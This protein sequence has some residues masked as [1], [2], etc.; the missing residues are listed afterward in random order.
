VPKCKP[1]ID[2]RQVRSAMSYH[3]RVAPPEFFR[4][5]NPGNWATSNDYTNLDA[6]VTQLINSSKGCHIDGRAGTGK[7]WYLRSLMVELEKR[8]IKYQAMAPTNVAAQLIDGQTIAKFRYQYTSARKQLLNAM[9]DVKYVFIDEI[10]MVASHEYETFILLK[11]M[12][13]DIRF[14]VSGDF[15]QLLAVEDEYKGDFLASAPLHTLCDGVRLNLTVCRR[16]DKKLFELCKVAETVKP[17]QFP[18]LKRTMRNIAY[19]H[20]T[21][22]RVNADCLREF[23]KGKKTTLVPA[24]KDGRS[25][26]MHLC[27]GMP[28]IAH[29]SRKSS[30]VYKTSQYTVSKIGTKMVTLVDHR[31]EI[32]F[33]L[34]GFGKFFWMGF[35]ITIHASQGCTIRERYTIHDWGHFCMS[36]RAKYV[37]LSRGTRC[38]DIQICR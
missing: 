37:A 13:P 29:Q 7:S 21:R 20:E 8:G 12:R 35:C 38:E 17:A 24:T 4:L 26:E 36:K 32:E 27:E 9:R 6:S 5:A 23:C 34:E 28:V 16:S 19:T 11:R 14:I 3:N 33:P 30:G 22:M 18:F 25:Q 15:E 1:E 31:G 10:S 2:A